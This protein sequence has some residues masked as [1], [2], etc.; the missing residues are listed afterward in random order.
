MI[1]YFKGH[2]FNEESAI[3]KEAFEA[4]RIGYCKIVEETKFKGMI[5]EKLIDKKIEFVSFITDSFAGFEVDHTLFENYPGVDHE[6]EHKINSSSSIIFR[7]Y[8]KTN[9][10]T[11]LFRHYSSSGIILA[12]SSFE[13]GELLQYD[14]IIYG[15]N[16]ILKETRTFIGKNAWHIEKVTY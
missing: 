14:E 3:S 12:E 7:K 5:I 8:V 16:N 10:E 6:I 9:Q 1:E 11:I 4:S 13:N 2:P 15:E